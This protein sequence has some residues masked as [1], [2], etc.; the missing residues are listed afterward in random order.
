M[1]KQTNQKAKNIV[2]KNLVYLDEVI[3][4]AIV[5]LLEDAGIEN[6]NEFV[7]ELQRI[8]ETYV[9]GEKYGGTN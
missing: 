5:N 7:I 9:A 4:A 1:T 2:Q 3:K 6:D 8:Y